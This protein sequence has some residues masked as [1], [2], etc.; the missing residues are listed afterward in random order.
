MTHCAGSPS[1]SHSLNSPEREATVLRASQAALR[2]LKHAEKQAKLDAAAA[3]AAAQKHSRRVKVRSSPK[4]PPSPIRD[5]PF[6][7]GRVPVAAPRT[8]PQ[9]RQPPPVSPTVRTPASPT[10]RHGD[11]PGR[12]STPKNKNTGSATVGSPS[13]KPVT[14]WG[15]QLLGRRHGRFSSQDSYCTLFECLSA[16][17]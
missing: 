17:A 3:E 12:H 14:P 1:P 11:T 10:E 6:S 4:K 16:D 2:A 5:R 8:P 13:G 9:K 15:R 7:A